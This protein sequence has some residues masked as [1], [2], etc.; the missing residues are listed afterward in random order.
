MR[1]EY[2]FSQGRKNPYTEK[3]KEKSAICTEQ[4]ETK[5]E[6]GEKTKKFGD[7]P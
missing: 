6:S 4:P 7:F 3:L 5:K 2:D 1:K